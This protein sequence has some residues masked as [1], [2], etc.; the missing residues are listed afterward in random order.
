M[1]V[2]TG[3]AAGV[4]VGGTAVAFAVARK[5][6]TPM[7]R[8]IADVEVRGIDT[9]AQTITLG[10]TPDTVLPGRYG[11]F[12]N[13]TLDYLK[14]GAVLSQTEQQVTR[15]LLTHVAEGE[16]IGRAATFS[17]WYYTHPRE[18]HIPYEEITVDAPVGP[19]PA[20]LFPAP[21]GASKTWVIAVHG[22]G[23]TRSEVLR[24]APV[25]REAGVTSL[26]VSYRND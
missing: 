5:A 7:T 3:L 18:L 16:R 4:V 25:F 23:T 8:R 14:L 11:L 2:A 21:R 17:G 9:R 12:V 13:G 1:A 22:R 19:C 20:W 26:A 10:R 24:A 6:V 15:K